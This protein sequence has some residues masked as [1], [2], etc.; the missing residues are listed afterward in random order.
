MATKK[1]SNIK[2][3]SSCRLVSFGLENILAHRLC[4]MGFT[5]GAT[6]KMLEN[7]GS[8]G[9]VMVEVKGSKLALGHKVADLIL[10]EEVV[11]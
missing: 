8:K 10:V 6:I 7:T 9:T 11:C 4:E 3:K 1:L 5:S 2:S